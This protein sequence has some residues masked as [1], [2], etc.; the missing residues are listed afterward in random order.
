[1]DNKKP[2]KSFINDNIAN[3]DYKKPVKSFT[4][5]LT[6]Q[7]IKLLLQD[8]KEEKP[9]HIPRGS[10]IRYFVKDND[11]TMKFRMGGVIKDNA[12]PKYMMVTN[13]KIDWSV[14]ITNTIFYMRMNLTEI[15][16]EY[17]QELLKKED[18]LKILTEE[19]K[20]ALIEIKKL[21]KENQLLKKKIKK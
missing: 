1:M 16:E 7:E 17:K 3:T 10:H 20:N 12:Y 6:K 15:I 2:K 4:E 8:Y 11:G 9:Q 18:E 13:G 21:I 5:K 19:H 14:Q